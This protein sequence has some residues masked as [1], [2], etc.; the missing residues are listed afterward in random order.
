MIGVVLLVAATVGVVVFAEGEG[1][2]DEPPP[3]SAFEFEF[4][5]DGDTRGAV[6]SEDRTVTDTRDTP[7]PAGRPTVTPTGAREFDRFGDPEGTDELYIAEELFGT[8]RIG[9]GDTAVV[10]E[11]DVRSRSGASGRRISGRRPSGSP[12]PARTAGGAS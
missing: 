6:P 3:E 5:R 7:V 11:D 2:T 1:A 8:G 9:A 12:G 10:S 4:A